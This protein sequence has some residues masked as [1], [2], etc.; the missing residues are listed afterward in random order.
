MLELK[1]LRK[2]FDSVV[3]LSDA[4]LS[5][6]EGEFFALLG[7]SGCGKTTL[8][9]IIAGFEQPTQ[10]ELL[11]D[12][13]NLLN[14]P[15]HERPVNLVFQRYALF[16]HLNVFENVAFGLRVSK[17]A[18]REIRSR[19]S[20]ALDLVRLAGFEARSVQ[21]LSGGQS[22][23]VALARA[24]IRKPK[25]L[26]LDEPL[27][28][29][30]LKLR[31]EMQVELRSLQRK[32]G[33]TFLLV[34]HDQD[35]A[36][37]LADRVAV[38]NLGVIEQVGTP[39]EVYQNPATLF[40]S[41]FIGSGTFLPGKVVASQLSDREPRALSIQVARRELNQSVSVAVDQPA[42]TSDQFKIGDKVQIFLRPEE[43]KLSVSD[44]SSAGNT[45][46]ARVFDCIFHGS[47]NLVYCDELLGEKTRWIVSVSTDVKL[48]PGQEVF[49]SWAESQGVALGAN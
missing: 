45:V 21:N 40:V 22:Q 44:Q 17:V 16:P 32:L 36:L 43:V 9:R 33:S 3:A 6:G 47:Q 30:D 14:I 7:P 1:K 46:K 8:L 42:A 48:L 25:V 38:M 2:E 15:A 31:Q 39:K 35:E 13:R 18:E 24:I 49:L 10:G 20:E 27:S 26:L 19:V 29:L 37:T 5:I 23:R 41:K 28:A 4:N 12:G 34:T 11:L